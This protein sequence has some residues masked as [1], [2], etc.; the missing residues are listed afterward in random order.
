MKIASYLVFLLSSRFFLFWSSDALLMILKQVSFLKLQV[1]PSVFSHLTRPYS[2]P[3]TILIDDYFTPLLCCSVLRTLTHVHALLMILVPNFMSKLKWSEENFHRLPPP[4][5]LVT[6]DEVFIFQSSHLCR[7]F[8]SFWP[9][10][11]HYS[12]HFLLCRLPFPAPYKHAISLYNF[13][14]ILCP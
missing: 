9:T 13:F 3:S 14:M 10:Q 11:G 2:I 8:H 5:L 6:I 12:N 4:Y 7:R 1:G